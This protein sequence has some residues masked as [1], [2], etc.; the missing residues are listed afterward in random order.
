LLLDR[1]L[2]VSRDTRNLFRAVATDVVRVKARLRAIASSES[3]L[4]ATETGYEV[5][6]RNIVDVLQAQN[7]L[8]SSQFDYA[9]SRYNYMLSLIL[10]KQRA[11]VLSPEDLLELN[12]FADPNA[13]VGR[14]ATLQARTGS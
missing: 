1:Q 11:G 14:I 2:T 4:E 13:P 3:A 10:L 7:R 6:T 12:R 9:D 8:Y 5:G